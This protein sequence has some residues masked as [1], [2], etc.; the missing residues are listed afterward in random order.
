ME[1]AMNV[2]GVRLFYSVIYLPL[3]DRD[4][5]KQERVLRVTKNT[6]QHD[7]LE[8]VTFSKELD[9][10]VVPYNQTLLTVQPW[11][12]VVCIVLLTPKSNITEVIHFIP[13]LIVLFQ[14]SI[15]TSSICF[16][17]LNNAARDL[18]YF[19]MLVC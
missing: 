4:V 2:L 15:I 1:V 17:L 19:R 3:E 7:L 14:L 18:E 13:G 6:P 9:V 10:I 12:D 11:V 5:R 8:Q 16:V